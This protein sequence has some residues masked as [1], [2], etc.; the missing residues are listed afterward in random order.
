MSLAQARADRTRSSNT[1]KL[2]VSPDTLGPPLLICEM[3][4]RSF[5]SEGKRDLRE[6]G[7]TPAAGPSHSRGQGIAAPA[8]RCCPPAAAPPTMAP[9]QAPREFQD[10][11][12]EEH[13]EGPPLRPEAEISGQAGFTPLALGG[14]RPGRGCPSH[15]YSSQA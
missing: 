8:S 9:T 3:G 15:C 2:A 1:S 12:I 13:T 11:S 6:P 14:L 10:D 4:R 7:H 5:R